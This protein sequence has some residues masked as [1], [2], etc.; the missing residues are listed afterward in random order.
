MIAVYSLFL[1]GFIYKIRVF[2]KRINPHVSPT[3]NAVDQPSTYQ[4][5]F[6]ISI[7]NEKTNIK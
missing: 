6:A 2:M 7:Y 1:I 4:N 5:P 3:D